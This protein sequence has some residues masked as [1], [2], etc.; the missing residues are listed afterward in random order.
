MPA[1]VT[2]SIIIPCYNYGRYVGQAIES[3]LAQTYRPTEVIVIND[4]ST[5]ETVETVS[6]YPV[7]LINQNNQGP[8][9]TFNNGIRASHGE[10]V[11]LL[12][13]DDLIHPQFLE[14]TVPVLVR[15]QKVAFVYTYA[16]TF[17]SEHAVL[18]A[19]EFDP[20]KLGE[21]SFMGGACLMRRDAFDAVGGFD[22]ALRH[23]EDWDLWLNL[24]ECG[25]V[26]QLVPRILFA[27]R[28][29]GRG[30]AEKHSLWLRWRSLAYL[31]RKHPRLLRRRWLA[32][33]AAYDLLFLL[34]TNARRLSPQAYEWIR[35]RLQFI[36]PRLGGV[37]RK[38]AEE[39]EFP[40]SNDYGYSE[41]LRYLAST[42][43]VACNS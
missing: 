27:Y 31:Y 41:M 9:Q 28:K 5:D 15:Q 20:R 19:K 7:I 35:R 26:G 12:S 37:D 30:L 17:G 22:P 33:L 38:R 25:Y 39:F 11:S 1:E 18:L 3:A 24:V 40:D 34:V 32:R 6:R 4:G 16:V 13:A 29:H 43:C 23:G 14:Y 8:A 21:G 10:F 2:I 42:G 36:K